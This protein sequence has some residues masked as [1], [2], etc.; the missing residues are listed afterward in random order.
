MI[1][2]IEAFSRYNAV[3][4]LLVDRYIR[5]VSF[6]SSLSFF[7]RPSFVS[8]PTQLLVRSWNTC[9]V[10]LV[11]GKRDRSRIKLF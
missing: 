9:V 4:I 8:F 5:G 11:G 3:I 1:L 6:L 2:C 7:F 10:A